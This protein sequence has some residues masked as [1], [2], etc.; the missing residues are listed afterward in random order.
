MPS[1]SSR[2]HTRRTTTGATNPASEGCVPSAAASGSGATISSSASR[3]V[4]AAGSPA[5]I[6]DR[7]PRRNRC[8]I[9]SGRPL[10]RG[11]AAIHRDGGAGHCLGGVAAQKDGGHAEIFGG[12][13]FHD[14]PLLLEQV[15][16]GLLDGNAFLLG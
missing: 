2:R 1:P 14:R 16:L 13:E 11:P 3:A 7:R 10:L 5:A 8:A 9:R 15:L 12:R 4:R 6:I